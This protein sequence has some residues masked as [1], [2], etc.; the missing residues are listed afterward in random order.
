M[1]VVDRDW[2]LRLRFRQRVLRAYST[3]CTVC[4]PQHRELLDA[5]SSAPL[6]DCRSGDIDAA[7]SREYERVTQRTE[8]VPR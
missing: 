3:R 6:G 1:Q 7:P 4:R 5:S 2:S 8:G